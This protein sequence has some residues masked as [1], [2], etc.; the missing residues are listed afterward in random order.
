MEGKP[1]L[2]A[3]PGVA[4]DV[5]LAYPRSSVSVCLD[6]FALLAWFQSEPAAALKV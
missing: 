5:D 2:A 1:R 3:E 4:A 6:S